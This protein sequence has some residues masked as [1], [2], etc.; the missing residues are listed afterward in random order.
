MV[1][2]AL[3]HDLSIVP[4]LNLEDW[5]AILLAATERNELGNNFNIMVFSLWLQVPF[6]S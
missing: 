3:G 6:K 2:I 5:V 4:D 1:V